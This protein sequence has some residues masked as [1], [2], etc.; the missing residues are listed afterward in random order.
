MRRSMLLAALAATVALPSLAAAQPVEFGTAVPVETLGEMRGGFSL[1]N[2]VDISL[3]VRSD[4]VLDGRVILQTVYQ[5]TDAAR[6]SIAVAKDGGSVQ[7]GSGTGTPQVIVSG[8]D[9]STVRLFTGSAS[10]PTPSDQGLRTVDLAPGQSVATPDGML[11]VVRTARGE[12]VT[13]AGDLLSTTHLMGDLLGS[14]TVNRANDLTINTT[15]T[16]DLN[17][18]NLSVPRFDAAA[19]AADTLAADAVRQLTQSRGF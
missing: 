9:G 18:G 11:S 7:T 5:V 17:V 8:A 13:L 10:A 14:V 4:T 6:L 15:T 19:L 3:A 2:G 1:P 16:I 12:A